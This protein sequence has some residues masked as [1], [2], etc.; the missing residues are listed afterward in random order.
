MAL[1]SNSQSICA[2]DP[3][4]TYRV[5]VGV[6]SRRVSVDIPGSHVNVSLQQNLHYLQLVAGGL[7]RDDSMQH[8]ATH[9]ITHCDV[10]VTYHHQ[11]VVVVDLWLK[12]PKGQRAARRSFWRRR[13]S[14]VVSW[15]GKWWVEGRI[16]V[17]M[18]LEMDN[19]QQ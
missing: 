7:F 14:V 10:C 16:S 18:K 17:E 9:F 4:P 3:P 11:H 12:S 19:G 13:L 1:T 6:I 15:W 5:Y 8:G 2:R